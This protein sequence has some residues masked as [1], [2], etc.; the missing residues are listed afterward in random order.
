MA[1]VRVI[2]RAVATTAKRRVT[3]HSSAALALLG[4]K[5]LRVLRS[6][7]SNIPDHFTSNGRILRWHRA[8]KALIVKSSSN[9]M[10]RKWDSRDRDTATFSS[11][12]RK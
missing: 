12:K 10:I 3:R 11:D 9:R 6:F 2:A 5:R 4:R 1:K 8:A 7:E